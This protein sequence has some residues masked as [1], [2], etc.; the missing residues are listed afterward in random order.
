MAGN[1]VEIRT[2][3]GRSATDCQGASLGTAMMTRTGLEV[4]LEYLSSPRLITS[5]LVSVIQS[6]SDLRRT[7]RSAASNRSTVAFSREP[8]GRTRDSTADAFRSVEIGSPG[9]SV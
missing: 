4:A 2:P 6:R 7:V 8:L 3:S 9:D 1:S 5:A